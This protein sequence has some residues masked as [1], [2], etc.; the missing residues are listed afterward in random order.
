M[1][2]SI[3]LILPKTRL[4]YGVGALFAV[5]GI[6]LLLRTSAATNSKSFEAESGNVSGKAATAMASSGI[7]GVGYVSLNSSGTSGGQT[8]PLPG[9]NPSGSLTA[10]SDGKTWGMVSCATD[11]PICIF[12]WQVGD[13]YTGSRGNGRDCGCAE[14]RNVQTG[15][16]IKKINIMDAQNAPYNGYRP[17]PIYNP[18]KKEWLIVTQSTRLNW[19]GNENELDRPYGFRVGIDGTLVGPAIE[20]SNQN[21]RG[22]VPHGVFDTAARKYYVEWHQMVVDYG[23]KDMYATVV[24]ENGT[25]TDMDFNID[26]TPDT[27]DEYATAVYNSQ[28]GEVIS[29]HSTADAGDCDNCTRA[30]D[31]YRLKISG[32]GK[33]STV[34]AK[35]RID[36]D[37]QVEWGLHSSYN[38]TT[39]T[40]AL[41]YREGTTS[42][43]EGGLTGTGAVILD[44]QGNVK[45]SPVSLGGT[46]SG[47][48]TTG[49]SCSMKTNL[50][51]AA[52][53]EKSVYIDAASTGSTK[54]SNIGNSGA[55]N[56]NFPGTRTG[57]S[58]TTDKFYFYG[59]NGYISAPGR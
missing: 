33:L 23:H 5:V 7:S 3:Q 40:I 41:I 52:V 53:Q 24:D 14:I 36:S 46:G 12:T 21:W 11:D 51:V 49:A 17:Y 10:I 50:C 38:P 20:L 9:S 1:E 31:V 45:A 54:I 25:V 59:N 48:W 30:I 55:A 42:R 27:L 16:L 19:D 35:N 58:S 8:V 34:T 18:F 47:Y 39:N 44:G 6:T 13:M 22:W 43:D 29:I 32:A 4:L 57:Y 26:Q 15:A 28:S 56:F 37:N 2:K